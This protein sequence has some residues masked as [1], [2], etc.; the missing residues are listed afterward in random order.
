MSNE[1]G[2]NLSGDP[3]DL[4]KLVLPDVITTKDRQRDYVKLLVLIGIN[5]GSAMLAA[6]RK[7]IRPSVT[8]IV[9]TNSDK[10]LRIFNLQHC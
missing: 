10:A 3:Y 2:V 5:A 4:G 8:V 9:R 7:H 6:T 1:L